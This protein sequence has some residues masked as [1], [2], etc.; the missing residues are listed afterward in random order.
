MSTFTVSQQMRNIGSKYLLLFLD[1]GGQVKKGGNNWPF[2]GGKGTLWEG[3]IKGVGFI[4]GK[5]SQLST[6]SGTINNELIHVSDWFPTIMS[7]TSCPLLNGT[8]PLDGHN[9][10]DAIR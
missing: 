10:W 3:G 7:A 2:R 5:P 6:K 9:Q 4:H 1:N 8:Q